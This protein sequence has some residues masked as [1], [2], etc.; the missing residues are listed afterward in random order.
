MPMTIKKE[1]LHNNQPVSVFTLGNDF[2][3]QQWH[4]GVIWQAFGSRRKLQGRIF[5]QFGQW[6]QQQQQQQHQLPLGWWWTLY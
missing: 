5:V 1:I 2:E 6:R 3:Q 4:Q